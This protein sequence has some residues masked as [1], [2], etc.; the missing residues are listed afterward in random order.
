[1]KK[2]VMFFGQECPHC[3]TMLSFVEKVEQETGI[4][5]ERL[6]VWH[7][8]KNADLMRSLKD[9]LLPKCGG[10][11]RVPTFL[12]TETNDVVCGE[13]G[14]EALKEWVTK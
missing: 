1:M 4:P 10:Q 6:E 14:Y 3:K 7:E 2:H 8:T 9:V 5:I 11:L 12:N 13:V